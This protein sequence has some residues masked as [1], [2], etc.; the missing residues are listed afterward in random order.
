VNPKPSP[1]PVEAKIYRDNTTAGTCR[2]V[3]LGLLGTVLEADP[4]DL[5]LGLELE[6]ELRLKND[7]NSQE[8]RLRAVVNQHSRLGV[9]LTFRV[10]GEQESGKLREIVYESWRFAA[11]PRRVGNARRPTAIAWHASRTLPKAG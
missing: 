2:V 4:A 1:T 3:Y 6:V 9:G 5:P 8:C 7:A 10:P 11:E